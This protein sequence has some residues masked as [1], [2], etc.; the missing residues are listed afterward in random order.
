MQNNILEMIEYPKNGILTQ[1]VVVNGKNDVTLFCMAAGSSIGDHTSKKS[2]FIYV[3]EGKGTFVLEGK[4]IKMV[5][6]AFIFMDENALHSLSAELNT[7][8]LL[9]LR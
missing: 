5:P 6:G 8:F 3:I 1:Q 4:K 9:S 7:S 2:G